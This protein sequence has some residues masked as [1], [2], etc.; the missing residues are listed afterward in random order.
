LWNG[1]P[2]GDWVNGL[3]NWT[4]D[5][6]ARASDI[7]SYITDKCVLKTPAQLEELTAAVEQS[8]LDGSYLQ[9]ISCTG[10]TTIIDSD[11]E[12]R[13]DLRCEYLYTRDECNETFVKKTEVPSYSAIRDELYALISE[14]L[15]DELGL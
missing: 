1:D 15:R 5:K 10:G 14:E 13:G 2:V 12:V 4:S 7:V 3:E 11:L 9:Y 6:L 8:F